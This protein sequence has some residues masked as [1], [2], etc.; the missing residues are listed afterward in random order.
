MKKFKI[1]MVGVGRATTYGRLFVENPETEVTALCEMDE[2]VLEQNGKEFNLGDKAL[3]TNYDD[4]INSDVDIVV[5]GTPIPFH[6][7]QSI[8]ALESG[9][10]VLSE[11]TAADNMDNCIKLVE[12]VRKSKAKY[13]LA[14]NCNYMYFALE[15]DKWIKAGN[16]GTPFYAEAD[17]VHEIRSLV[18]G[19]WRQNRAPLHYCSHSLGPVLMWMDDYVVRCSA[20]GRDSRSFENK[21][22]GNIDM[23]V[24]LFETSKGATIKVLRSSVALRRP[25]LCSYSI[26]GTKGSLESAREAYDGVG[27]RYFDGIDPEEG[28]RIGVSCYDPDAPE[29]TKAGGHGTSEYYLINDFLNSIK[30]DITPPIDIVKGMDM[31]VPGIIAHEAA[32]KGGIWLDVPRITD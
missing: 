11:V 32:K 22:D 25:A 15:W 4:F 27:Y 19:K 16:I 29:I 24:A 13:M 20:S 10:H 28:R 9:K 1:G 18:D 12:A 26:Y 21:T 30:A 31:T 14:E 8:K 2:S 6:A 23:Q 17:Y 5:L 7:E 3:F